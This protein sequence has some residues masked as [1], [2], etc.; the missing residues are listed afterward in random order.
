M[1]TRLISKKILR[2]S[3]LTGSRIEARS[4]K[5]DTL[6]DV[7][8]HARMQGVCVIVPHLA[9]KMDGPDRYNNRLEQYSSASNL[10]LKAAP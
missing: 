7:E 6:L 9:L 1:Q 10:P 5:K 4:R 3:K 8:L 2:D